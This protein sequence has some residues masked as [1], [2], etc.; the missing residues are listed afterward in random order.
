M[1]R[2]SR[3]KDRGGSINENMEDR[4][5]QAQDRMIKTDVETLYIKTWKRQEPRD[6]KLKTEDCAE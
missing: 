1:V 3:K 4:S 6:K 5:E 2:T